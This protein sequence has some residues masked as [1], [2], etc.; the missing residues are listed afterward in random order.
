M[1]GLD[2][3]CVCG[4]TLVSN[5][6]FGFNSADRDE[7]TYEFDCEKCNKRYQLVT[8]TDKIGQVPRSGRKLNSYIKPLDKLL[9]FEKS[10]SLTL[11][12]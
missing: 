6:N 10:K 2:I 4:D 12:D 5:N 3:E 7:H 11:G 8:W 1:S 9:E